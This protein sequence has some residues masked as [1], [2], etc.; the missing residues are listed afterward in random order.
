MGRG[1]QSVIEGMGTFMAR[2][3]RGWLVGK[4]LG[5]FG[6]LAVWGYYFRSC[7][8]FS[9]LD[10]NNRST[11]EFWTVF[12]FAAIVVL[13]WLMALALVVIAIFMAELRT[14]FQLLRSH[15]NR[16]EHEFPAISAFKDLWICLLWGD[17][18]NVIE[19]ARL[20]IEYSIWAPN[21]PT[22]TDPIQHEREFVQT[23][24]SHRE[25][26][27]ELTTED[28]V[29]IDNCFVLQEKREIIEHY[30]Q[31]MTS[32]PKRLPERDR[33]LIEATIKDGYLA[34]QFLIAGLM[35]QFEED[36]QPVITA[37]LKEVNAQRVDLPNCEFKR[38]QMFIFNCWLLWGPSIPIGV[39]SRWRTDSHSVI[40]LQY[41][42]GDENNS[43]PLLPLVGRDGKAYKALFRYVMSSPFAVKASLKV[44][45]VWIAAIPEA[46]S[47][48]VA[49][50]LEHIQGAQRSIW[51]PPT[52]AKQVPGT[53]ALD[54]ADAQFLRGLSDDASPED[55]K[56][57]Y[58]AY[59]WV[60][61]VLC[62]RNEDGSA[63]D[64]VFS[65]SLAE[66]AGSKQSSIA[67]NERDF[68]WLG[69][70][71]F[72]E[73]GNLADDA[74]Y[75]AFKRQLAFKSLASIEGLMDEEIPVQGGSKFREKFVLQY[76]CASDD[77]NCADCEREAKDEDVAPTPSR[78]WRSSVKI[79]HYFANLI[80]ISSGDEF[81]HQNDHGCFDDL[82]DS[83]KFNSK[84]K[85]RTTFSG[86]HLP[87][88]IDWFY[89]RMPR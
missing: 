82:S 88:V 37:F 56:S 68:P 40:A 4:L 29:T 46:R 3:G 53:L 43:L 47:P 51:D 7:V 20:R 81:A 8:G 44:R 23:Y 38:I 76:A 10:V 62:H 25:L 11:W 54:Y 31:S 21:E 1:L 83:L 39:C 80:G 28:E 61:F 50:A 73:H 78:R 74:T 36:W 32:L 33:F 65:A 77:A 72:F 9:T 84:W 70:F 41:G 60:M 6:L 18:K 67:A 26:K 58:S 13:I 45:P 5:L 49:N 64:P 34:P 69:M 89:K 48:D 42:Y 2:N 52:V 30:F 57:Y 86:C 15:H 24:L 35:S 12:S 87:D 59:I 16:L 63:G 55:Q 66:G 79:R 27:T 71:P 14:P 19:T 17:F 85:H 75:A 22:G